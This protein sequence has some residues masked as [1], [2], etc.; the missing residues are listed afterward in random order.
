MKYEQV[1]T[2]I[3]LFCIIYFES[4]HSELSK[5]KSEKHNVFSSDVNNWT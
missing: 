5:V 3:C 2:H 1:T 4:Q